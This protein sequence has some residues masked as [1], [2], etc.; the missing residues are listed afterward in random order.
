[1]ARSYRSSI[2]LRAARPRCC[3]RSW[4]HNRNN[5]RLCI[6]SCFSRNFHNFMSVTFWVQYAIMLLA[7]FFQHVEK[8]NAACGFS[9]KKGNLFSKN[10]FCR[11][12]LV[13]FEC[14]RVIHLLKA[15]PTYPRAMARFGTF[16]SKLAQPLR[17]P[18]RRLSH[19]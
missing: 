15:I 18:L 1:M 6:V 7:P 4:F 11:L 13:Q 10:M 14:P 19:I 2:A 3:P 16:R 17:N 12:Q 9:K 8:G 5:R